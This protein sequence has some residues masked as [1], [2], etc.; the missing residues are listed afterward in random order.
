MN[1]RKFVAMMKTNVES[2][3]PIINDT[4]AFLIKFKK[5]KNL[6]P[7]LLYQFKIVIRPFSDGQYF[8]VNRFIID[9][10]LIHFILSIIYE[11]RRIVFIILVPWR[12]E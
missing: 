7:L 1:L 5:T 4:T 12:R 11:T 3:E 2:M 10:F 9:F 6:D 8:P